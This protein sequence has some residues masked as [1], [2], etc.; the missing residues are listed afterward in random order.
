[1]LVLAFARFWRCLMHG[2]EKRDLKNDE[3]RED[4]SSEACKV[5]QR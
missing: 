3:G 5:S 4:A 1:M 2:G